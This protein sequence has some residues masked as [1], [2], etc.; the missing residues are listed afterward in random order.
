M[1]EASSVDAAL[2]AFRKRD[3]R[4]VL[5]GATL[6]YLI[7]SLALGAAFLALTWPAASAMMAWYLQTLRAVMEGG[8]P[9]D[10]PMQALIGVAPWYAAFSLGGWV[11]FAAYEAACLRWLVRGERGG[12]LGL[13]FGADTWRVF[14]TYVVWILLFIAFGVVVVVL[15]LGLNALSGAV[16]ALRLI[17]MLVG[18]LIPLALA[19]LLIWGATRLS[20]AAAASVARK[21]FAFFDAWGATRGQ[22]WEMLGAFVILMAV[23]L[24]V[25][26]V[27]SVLI[28]IPI[29]Q[30]M[31]PLM[32]EALTDAS[33][34]TL[35]QQAMEALTAPLMLALVAV[36]AVSSIVLALLLYVGW[37]GVNARAV[38]AS[39]G[40]TR[41]EPPA[42]SEPPPPEASAAPSA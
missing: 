4:F 42:A 19:A 22:F 11:L 23:Y 35:M 7:V 27:L 9:S 32:A 16:P 37:F 1:A 38:A 30:A 34:E 13:S 25:S 29:T 21:R 28:R 2:F 20:P 8:E 31:Y 36:Y 26:T 18:A 24:G 3:R 6:A 39:A 41:T 33:F 14:A 5:T 17:V 15:Y 40:A 12:F 10:P